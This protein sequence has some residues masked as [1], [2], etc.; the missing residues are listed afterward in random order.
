MREIDVGFKVARHAFM[1]SF[2]KC[3]GILFLKFDFTFK[4][5]L[6]INVVWQANCWDYGMGKDSFAMNLI[7]RRRGQMKTKVEPSFGGD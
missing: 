4:L 6:N 1:V 7:N 5:M 2:R 3:R